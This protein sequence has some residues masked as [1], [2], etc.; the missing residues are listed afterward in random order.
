MNASL[1]NVV[2]SGKFRICTLGDWPVKYQLALDALR[3][4]LT[5]PAQIAGAEV[6]NV[7]ELHYE[8]CPGAPVATIDDLL[9]VNELEPITASPSEM[10]AKTDG[11]SLV[12][13]LNRMIRSYKAR[14]DGQGMA[15][16]N[17]STEESKTEVKRDRSRSRERDNQ[18]S[19]DGKYPIV[20]TD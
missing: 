11:A 2:G 9:R 4:G 20:I 3:C 10:K 19:T 16:N 13:V 17:E 7:A 14:F 8:Q 12:R 1:T 15:L 5:L 18:M 6:A